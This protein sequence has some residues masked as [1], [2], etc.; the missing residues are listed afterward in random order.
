MAV[1]TWQ[2][3][4]GDEVSPNVP[5]GLPL[6]NVQLYIL[7]DQMEPV[8]L[9]AE[10]ELYIAGTQLGLG[11]LHRPDLTDKAFLPN[12]FGDGQLYRTGDL[13]CYREDGAVEFHGRLD[14]QVKLHGLRIELGEIEAVLRK[15]PAVR[16]C[17]VVVHQEHLV[18]YV[19]ATGLSSDDLRQHAQQM[20]PAYMVP[21]V[22][23]LLD[24]LPL[25]SNEKINRRALP[26]PVIAPSENGPV[27]PRNAPETQLIAIW[28]R[29][30]TRHPIGITDNFFSGLGGD[31]LAGSTNICGGR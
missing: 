31:S 10:G 9:G 29:V 24:K 25:T 14:H 1:T 21:P 11:Y 22:V 23:V 7:D 12:P 20:L 6:S 4:A 17:V 3:R 5:I 2:C 18:A 13:A 15:H 27:A 8:A 30:L 26:E 28:E 19:V 16:D